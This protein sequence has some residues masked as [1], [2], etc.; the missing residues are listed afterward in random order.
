MTQAF[1]KVKTI[2]VEQLGVEPDEVQMNSTFVNDLGA[3]S[4]DIVELVMAFEE[5]FE[6]E[7]PDDVAE[8]IK[9]VG[10]AVNIVVYGYGYVPNDPVTQAFDRVKTIIVK[11]LGVEPDEVQM[12]STFVDDLGADSLDIVELVMAFEEEFEVEIPDD[13]AERIKT[14][15]EAVNIVLYGYGYVPNDENSE[16]SVEPE[17]SE[18]AKNTGLAN[19]VLMG[20]EKVYFEEKFHGDRGHGFAAER[21]NDLYDRMTGKDARIVGDDNAKNGADRIVNGANIQSK[22]CNSG[23]KCVQECFEGGQFRYYNKDGSPMQI[24]VPSDKYDD[25]V[26]AMQ[27]RIDKGQIRGV[28]NAEDI[29]CKGNVTYEQAK[30]IAKAGTIESL[31]Y[32]AISGIKIGAYSGG[33]SAAINF[34]V[35]IWNG[36]SFEVALE[37]SVK[38][39]LQVGGMAWAGSIIAGQLTKAGFNTM[40]VPASDALVKAMGP[41]LSANLVNAFRDGTKIYG[42]AAMKSASK[43]LRG[44]VV[45]G[46]ATVAIMSA[47]DV[48][49]IFRGRISAGQ[50]VKNLVNTSAGVAG[51]L[52]GALVGAPFGPLGMLIAG[53][54]ASKA[55]SGVSKTITDE[56][57]EDDSKKMCRILEDEF[58]SVAFNFILNENET[59]KVADKLTDNLDS[60]TLKDMYA[61]DNRAQFAHNLI[62]EI[63]E[64]VVESRAHIY[65]P[66]TEDYIDGLKKVLR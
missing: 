51:G 15:G 44:N 31:T 32:D 14:V 34:A 64:P 41:K 53:W 45:T 10:E 5:E 17:L 28:K 12:N 19:G 22:Y 29:I 16:I 33:I 2:I 60:D 38:A 1:D 36:E 46:L 62:A 24:E 61:A 27:N 8:R 25:A 7:I 59:K 55:A 49:N 37:N 6:V 3:D 21:A 66:S 58:Q 48:I 54:L 39:G 4:L 23:S 63:A 26:K 30:N 9:T 52:G 18:G 13:V 50:L 47:G 56:M 20:T 42:A 40:L 57:I 35:C 11:Q 43:L 65:L